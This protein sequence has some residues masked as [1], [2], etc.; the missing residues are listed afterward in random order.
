MVGELRHWHR[1]RVGQ[2]ERGAKS[3]CL[4]PPE[5]TMRTCMRL[6]MLMPNSSR[7]SPVR[8]SGLSF[9]YQAFA[10][11]AMNLVSLL[12]WQTGESSCTSR[13]SSA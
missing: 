5:H 7:S 4:T 12:C 2:A 9:N 1:D 8:N 11:L 10:L 3:E 6:N 13:H